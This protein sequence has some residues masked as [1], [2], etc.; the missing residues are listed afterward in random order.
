MRSWQEHLLA[1]RFT[2]GVVCE[3]RCSTNIPPSKQKVQLKAQVDSGVYWRV[4]GTQLA[5]ALW[6]VSAGRHHIELVQ[7]KTGKVLDAVA[8]NVRSAR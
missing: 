8:F 5:G 6:P 7:A 1:R 2:T 3:T 4:D